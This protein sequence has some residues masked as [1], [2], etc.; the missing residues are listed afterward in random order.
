MKT[1][2]RKLNTIQSLDIFFSFQLEFIWTQIQK[3]IDSKI[4]SQQA[5]HVNISKK[6][7]VMIIDKKAID[8]DNDDEMTRTQKFTTQIIIN[9]VSRKQFFAK[10]YRDSSDNAFSSVLSFAKKFTVVVIIMKR[11][12][13]DNVIELI[14]ICD[15]RTSIQ[16]NVDD[17]MTTRF[18]IIVDETNEI[19]AQNNSIIII[20][21]LKIISNFAKQSIK[22]I[23]KTQETEQRCRANIAQHIWLTRTYEK[24]VK[25][26]YKQRDSTIYNFLSVVDDWLTKLIEFDNKNIEYSYDL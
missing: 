25:S 5:R 16:Y 1:L 26:I 18:Q 20:V 7:N 4:H 13:F 2:S 3:T 15:R 8:E 6:N 24:T 14:K 9:H 12:I 21:V 23:D 19:V 22:I 11:M 10:R 17:E